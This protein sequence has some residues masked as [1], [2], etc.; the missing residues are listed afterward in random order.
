ML[1]CREDVQRK[2]EVVTIGKKWCEKGR[3][4]QRR[5]DMKKRGAWFRKGKQMVHRGR[6][7]CR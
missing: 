3:T 1:Q 7:W 4:V 2:K 6:R 5:K